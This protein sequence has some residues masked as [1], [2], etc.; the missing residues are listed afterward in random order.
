MKSTTSTNKNLLYFNTTKSTVS[1]VALALSD[2][3]WFCVGPGIAT[4]LVWLLWGN[5]D[6]YLPEGQISGRLGAHL[7]LALFCVMW[8]WVRLR[9]YTYRKPFWFELKEILRTILIFSIID[10][11]ILAFSKWHVSRYFWVF[12]WGTIG[13][14]LPLGRFLVKK[15]LRRSGIWLKDC[16]IIGTGENALEAY[17]ALKGEKELGL[18]FKYFF[19]TECTGT[20]RYLEG[21]RVLGNE[22]VLWRTT[23]P[24]HTQ[25]VIALEDGQEDIREHW[26]QKMAL[27]QCRVVS[28][29]PSMRGIPLNSTDAS[30]LFKYE[31]LL[32]KINTNLTKNSSRWIKRAFDLVM[33]VLIC[34]VF[35]P[36][37]L[38]LTLWVM[39]DGGKPFYG[40]TRIGKNGKAFTCWKFRSMGL[41]SQEVLAHLLATD[42]AAK[43]EW[44]QDFKLR[45]DPRVTRVGRLLRKTSLDELPQLW[46]VLRGD[47][48]LVGPRPIIDEEL[49]RYGNSKDYYLMAKPGMTGLWQVS[50]RNDVDYDTR[51]YLDAWYVKNW[52]LWNDIVIMFKTIEIVLKR[53]GAY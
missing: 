16:V 13:L 47:M 36:V 42:P 14:T 7:L 12:T 1:Q 52:S 31:L 43:A 33:T 50:G 10:L 22:R 45:N 32:L 51:V 53:D 44:E 26:I 40:H 25:Y 5:L 30:Y 24:R 48:S 27:H 17:K 34:L 19:S 49:A 46:N 3:F 11:A 41:D 2:L 28:V 39:S 6:A 38:L 23:D 15:A 20:Q 21:L 29:V 35:S 18:D 37:L 9:H 8:F 4:G